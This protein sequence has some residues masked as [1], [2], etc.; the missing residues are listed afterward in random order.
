M[1]TYF[2][3]S[4]PAE[5]VNEYSKVE[6]GPGRPPHWEMVFWWTRKPLASARAAIAAALLPSGAYPTQEQ[7]L[8]DLFP[9]RHER[10][11]AHACNPS[12]RLV[13]KL[14]GKKLLDPFAGF[15]SIPLEAM[16]LGLDVTAV[17]LLPTAYVFLKAVLE[18]P[19]RYGREV[20]ETTGREVKEL[21]LEDVAKKFS[22]ARQISDSGRYKVPRLIYDVARWGRWVAQRLRE[23]PDIKELYDENVAVYIGTWEVKC[24]A[25]DHYTPLVG[26]WWLARVKTGKEYERLA[27][28]TWR[29][30]KIEVVDLNEECRKIKAGNCNMLKAVVKTGGEEEE[31][32]SVEWGGMKF[33]VPGKNVDGK[34][35]V[36]KCL[37]CRVDIDHRVVDG[38]LKKP[39][40][41]RKKE[42]EWYVKWA[43]RQWNNNLERYLNGEITLQELRN[44]LARPILLIKVKLKNNDLEFELATPQD[45]EK[46]WKALEKLK[47]MWGDPDI[48]YENI[49]PYGGATLG[50]IYKIFIKYR[51]LF[52][53]RQLLT[54]VKLV[55]LVRETGKRV[56]EEKLREGW[57]REDAHKYA[58]AVTTYLAIALCK[59]ADWNSIVSGWQL[60]YLI[61]AHTLAMRGIA[62]VWNWGE[63]NPLSKY[64]GT[65][66]AMLENVID[67]L[68]YLVNAVSGSPSGVRVLLDD[69]TTLDKLSGEKFD[70]IVTDPPYAYDVA[71]AEL[72]DFYY[73]WLKRA[74]SDNDGRSLKPRFL[75]ESFFDEFG[76]EIPTQWKVFAPREVSE[77][78]GR[79]EY[80]KSEPFEVLL[81]RA[82]TN[83]LRFLKENGHLVVYYVAKKPEAWAAFVRALWEGAGLE[84]VAAHP[85]A[86]E[87][88]ESVVAR[89]KASVLGGYLSVWRRRR[90]ERPLELSDREAVVKAVAER[91][92]QFSS[93]ARGA[94]GHTLWVYAYLAALSFLTEHWPVKRRGA[95]LRA[96]ELVEAAV[97]LAFEALLR[98][99]G[100]ELADAASRAYLALRLLEGKE[101]RVDSDVLSH[102]ERAVGGFG[103]RLGEV[104][105]CEAG[106]GRRG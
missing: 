3:P 59:H 33:V 6:K 69:A 95:E 25:G 60:S 52:N 91:F 36:A 103:Q 19:H 106:G 82:F 68:S 31:G 23:D 32:G 94:K 98:D 38:R 43:L 44:S 85:V 30:G 4:F 11:T 77:S 79:R 66:K 78:E 90:G 46:L 10:K 42:G 50:D 9:C 55:K 16:R 13:E 40:K 22:G 64:R 86:T 20:V 61:A 81:A 102:V 48:P 34:G 62:I 28:M 84:L 99:A 97:D 7:F 58:E 57:S 67:G 100:V 105:A 74:L 72:S 87:S 35:E 89:G 76:E 14:R 41:G 88:E 75:Q 83:L 51:N 24:P 37:H 70:L 56:E 15:G 17:E 53:P 27:W 101:G 71:Y 49:Q 2:M 1:E 39:V 63:Y 5:A 21:G 47:Q 80:F 26:N 73:V 29:D 45:A 65:I 92:K 8:N 12:P 93:Q 18:Y 104:G 54:L 96:E